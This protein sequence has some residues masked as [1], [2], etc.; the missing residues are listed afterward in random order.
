MLQLSTPLRSFIAASVLAFSASGVQASEYYEQGLIAYSMGEYTQ[1]EKHFILAAE[2]NEPG[3][4]HMLARLYGEGKGIEADAKQQF[5]WNLVAAE[6]GLMQAQFA[7]AEVY[8]GMGG[9][10]NL[11][12]AYRWYR[13]AADQGHHV[14]YY[15]LAEMH[16]NG[17][18]AVVN[19]R[20]VKR[21]YVVAAAEFDVFAQKGDAYSQDQLGSMYEHGKGI[22]RNPLRALAWYQRAALQGY[23]SAQFNLGRMLAGVDGIDVNIAEASYWLDL[24]ARQGHGEARTLL[25][26]LRDDGAEIALAE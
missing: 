18:G 6:Q 2:A 16:E 26:R 13:L 5:Q 7:V 8:A 1:A 12:Q 11:D 9:D 14:A 17:Q 15:R 4:A 3:A 25:A 23:A 22:A 19:A 24:A 21:L 20:V 10:N